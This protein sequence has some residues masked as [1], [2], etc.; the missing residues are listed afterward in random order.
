L[1]SHD[2]RGIPE[3]LPVDGRVA[4]EHTG[5]V[6]DLS[7]TSR[8]LRISSPAQLLHVQSSKVVLVDQLPRPPL[9]SW[10]LTRFA[11]FE[12]GNFTGITFLDTFFIKRDQSKNEAIHFHELVHVIQW[13]ILGPERF[14]Y[15]YAD[16]LERF[17]YEYSPLEAMAYEAEA[18]FVGSTAKFDAERLV[19]EALAHIN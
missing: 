18:R 5:D 4:P 7:Q 2:A 3:I 11:D 19:A 12:N 1:S 14:L 13:R 9:S 6:C 16:G 8:L 15:L 17:G 10:G